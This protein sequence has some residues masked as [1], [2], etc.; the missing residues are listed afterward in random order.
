MSGHV[1]NCYVQ[2]R[3]GEDGPLFIADRN[4]VTAHLDGYAVIPMEQYDRF[5]L[6]TEEWAAMRLRELTAPA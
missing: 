4:T 2:G 1:R 6:I 3:H 5:I